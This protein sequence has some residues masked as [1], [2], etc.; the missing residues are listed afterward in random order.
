MSTMTLPPSPPFQ[1]AASQSAR[2]GAV[3]PTFG[4]GAVV[5][6][7][8]YLAAGLI[9]SY[10]LA[11]SGEGDPTVA[12]WVTLGGAL[13]VW[14][15][16]AALGGVGIVGN[17]RGFAIVVLALNVGAIFMTTLIVMAVVFGTAV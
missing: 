9:V 10:F 12:V 7:G 17:A 11:L 2:G 3:L 6:G 8:L 16:G 4:V 13:V 15:V 14:L 1:L 5:V